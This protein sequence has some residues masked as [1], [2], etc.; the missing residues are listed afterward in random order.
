MITVYAP[1][2]GCTRDADGPTFRVRPLGARVQST[3]ALQLLEETSRGRTS[4]NGSTA[5]AMTTQHDP[6]CAW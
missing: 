4:R 2:F 1:V 3:A 5:A 6:G